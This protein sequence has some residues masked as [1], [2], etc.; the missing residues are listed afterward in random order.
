MRFLI[1]IVVLS[2]STAVFAQPR[3]GAGRGG[4]R[5]NILVEGQV[6]DSENGL[7]LEFATV[8]ITNKRDNS[9]A[10]GGLTDADG[11]FSISCSP[12]PLK[13][14]VD[15]LGYE[16][17]VIDP[18]AIDR[19]KMK[20]GDRK[21]SL[22][23]I[24][25]SVSN[26]AL[27]EVE[28]RAEKSETTF[29]L[30]K[31]VFN[32]GKDLANKGG[33]A[34]E[35]LDNVPSV[36]VDI[37]GEVSL[38]GSTGVRILVDG[39]P[40][41]LTGNANG[42]KQI[43]ASTIESIEVITNP[44][45]RYEAE[46]QAGII[47]IILKKEKRSGFNGSF[48]VTGGYPLSLG[49]GANLNY[50]KGKVNWFVNYGINYRES[51]GGGK[52]YQEV[53]T[54]TDT[55]YTNQSSERNRS[56]FGNTVRGGLDYYFTEKDVLTASVSY[57]RENDNNENIVRY[58]D[59]S[60][61]ND[62]SSP[63]SSTY[64]FDP[65]E[66]RESRLQYSVN[67][68]KEIA[69]RKHYLNL[70]ASYE[71]KLEEEFSQFEETITYHAT[72]T[73]KEL[74]QRNFIDEGS[75]RWI[76]K[77]DYVQ[78]L[79][80]EDHQYEVGINGSFRNIKND[81]KVEQQNSAIWEELGAFTNN[82]NYDET[83]L[84]AY[85]QYGNKID[86]FSYQIGL[87]Y[88]WSDILT[89]L[90]QT[91]YK[92]DRSYPGFF[93]SLFLN[94]AFN[95]MNAFQVSYSRRIQRP[96]F[97]YLNPFITFTDRRNLFSGNPD[98]DPEYTDSYEMNWLN[99]WQKAT[100]SSGIFYRHSTGVIDR[101][102]TFQDGGVI[103]RPENLNTRDDMGLEMNLSYF[104]IEWWRVDANASFYRSLTDGTDL[105]ESYEADA[106][107]ANGRVTNKITLPNKSDL[108][109][110]YNFRGPRA[111]IQG[112][113]SAVHS[114]DL[115]Y[116]IDFLAKKN[117]TF[118]LSIRDLLNSRKRMGET[119]GPNFYQDSEFQWRG[120]TITGTFSYRINQKK[121]RSRGSGYGGEQ[122]GEGGF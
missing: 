76:A 44:S 84:G 96:R 91:N 56:G 14:E 83:I 53:Y 94:Y 5:P 26:T 55:L 33:T 62:A 103:M 93:P 48:D 18:I 66:E 74:L 105:D 11:N 72:N 114:L 95:E 77:V 61:F 99:K 88:E 34:E 73:D 113:R 87:R 108:Q 119:F 85:V 31:T 112:N 120:R 9:I 65:E 43:P 79:K 20:S 52:T 89:E 100:L 35:I 67:Y 36:T 42:L 47:N 121:R 69:G 40:A 2:L 58:E 81:F 29:S 17:T 118:T 7:G 101:V 64:R 13:A 25:L 4:E 82:F 68:R 27:G 28:I 70:N 38:R 50:R 90:S 49:L 12:G 23:V 10:G 22:G 97:F 115:G 122:G 98:L 106:L 116:S 59:Y 86:K 19:E 80:G 111:S 32:V 3:E 92:N 37:E 104:G 39:K 45:A 30:D 15:F 51:V 6:V 21:V 110:R 109:I 41:G 75:K 16:K 46:G 107:T 1:S 102:K 71:D 57:R 24:R 54:D 63:D 60:N 8:A 78:P 117:A